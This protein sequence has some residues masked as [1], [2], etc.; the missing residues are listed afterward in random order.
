MT[1]NNNQETQHSIDNNIDSRRT[2][3]VKWFRKGFGFLIDVD[4]EDREY[5]V[6]HTSLIMKDPTQD[7][8]R[9]IYKKLEKGEYVECYIIIDSEGRNCAIDVT[10]V[11]RG[12]L[13]CETNSRREYHNRSEEN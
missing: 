8:D 6:H 11:N 10:G 9:R 4:R 3:R 2:A 1:D 13:M 5:F 7:D 12:P